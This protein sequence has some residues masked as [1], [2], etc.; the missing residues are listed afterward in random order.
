MKH[1][2]NFNKKNNYFTTSNAKNTYLEPTF[3][4]DINFAILTHKTQFDHFKTT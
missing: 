3:K 1:C 4:G 2:A